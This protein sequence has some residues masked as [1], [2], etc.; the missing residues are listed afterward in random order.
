MKRS[1]V[2]IAILVAITL[3]GSLGINTLA[4]DPQAT[5]TSSVIS[6]SEEHLDA[7]YLENPILLTAELYSEHFGIS[8][9]EAMN[10]LNLEDEAGEL[11]SLLMQNEEKSFGGMYID[12]EPE[13][14]IVIMF[15]TDINDID[16][17]I[18][19]YLTSFQSLAPYIELIPVKYSLAEL[20]KHQSEI[21]N[22]LKNNGVLVDSG[23]AI[24]NNAI[25]INTVSEYKN[26]TKQ[27]IDNLKSNPDSF[28]YDN[29]TINEVLSLATPA[30]SPSNPCGGIELV[31]DW[32]SYSTAGFS[33]VN[34]SGVKGITTAAHC[35]NDRWWLKS[36]IFDIVEVPFVSESL[37]THY[38]I[39]WHS[40]PTGYTI[41]NKIQIAYDGS[42]T[43]ITATKN[44][45]S[46]VVGSTVYKY[47]RTTHLT[48]G[49]ISN[50]SCYLSYFPNSSNTFI[51]VSDYYDY[52]PL[53]AQGDSGGP[54]FSGHTAYGTTC[55]SDASGNA[56]YM[57]VNYISTL[58]VSVLTSP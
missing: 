57:A 41:S 49:K 17:T 13:F 39:Q 36:S 46:Q 11:Q 24:T 56:Y 29:I 26:K 52:D 1:R 2:L 3:I 44:R 34:S 55:A 18:E 10:R 53:C 33:V 21:I 5:P 58:G 45:T 6:D 25:W 43:T 20:E 54:W 9:E 7:K 15:K 4:G 27:V 35:S 28:Q 51:Q 32:L 12:D 14:K 23:L 19:K 37:G 22:L 31:D 16:N 50:L 48:C 8:I 47:G 40:C 30:A 38:D 42:T